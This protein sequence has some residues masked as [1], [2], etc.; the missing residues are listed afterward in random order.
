MWSILKNL[1]RG[2]QD[3]ALKWSKGKLDKE[4]IVSYFFA[5]PFHRVKFVA[6][7]IFYIVND[8]KA[9]KFGCNKVDSLRLKMD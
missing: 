6:K 7:H 1:S 9:R 3:Q 5:Y 2:A 4:M 8:G